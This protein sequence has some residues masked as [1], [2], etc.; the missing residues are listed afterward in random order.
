MHTRLVHSTPRDPC[1]TQR[2]SNHFEDCVPSPPQSAGCDGNT[3]FHVSS[4]NPR[5]RR[6]ISES[7]G[8]EFGAGESDS[9]EQRWP[10]LDEDETDDELVPLVIVGDLD[11]DITDEEAFDHLEDDSQNFNDGNANDE[12]VGDLG[13]PTHFDSG[14][15]TPRE[16]YRGRLEKFGQDK[17]TIERIDMASY[18]ACMEERV[19][20]W[21]AR[22]VP[23]EGSTLDHDSHSC[24]VAGA[25]SD[26]ER[27][28]HEWSESLSVGRDA[29]RRL[30]RILQ[31]HT[32]DRVTCKK[33][34]LRGLRSLRR[35]MD[36]E[37][38]A[39]LGG[40]AS[41]LLVQCD[42]SWAC[43][44]LK[45]PI[46]IPISDPTQAV[47]ML[48]STLY[49]ASFEPESSQ[50]DDRR[51]A[52]CAPMWRYAC[53]LPDDGP[54]RAE[55]QNE[56]DEEVV[57]LPVQLFSDEVVAAPARG[58]GG[59]KL[60]A[61]MM[62][63]V[64]S[65]DRPPEPR[66][67]HVSRQSRAYEPGQTAPLSFMPDPHRWFAKALNRGVADSDPMFTPAFFEA[68]KT[69]R[70][71]WELLLSDA[72]VMTTHRLILE[73]LLAAWRVGMRVT[74]WSGE[75]VIVRP[76]VY[77]F[78]GDLPEKSSALGLKKPN[79]CRCTVCVV[80]DDKSLANITG[81]MQWR[82]GGVDT[83]SL[84]EAET[85]NPARKALD[86]RGFRVPSVC[87]AFNPRTPDGSPMPRCPWQDTRFAA[88]LPAM[89]KFPES[90]LRAL[91]PPEE[92]HD[93]GGGHCVYVWEA[94]KRYLLKQA[95][96][97]QQTA[98]KEEFDRLLRQ[99]PEAWNHDATR[100]V[101]GATV[102]AGM[103]LRKDSLF[104]L[105]L[106]DHSAAQHLVTENLMLVASGCLTKWGKTQEAAQIVRLLA[107]FRRMVQWC[108]LL[109]AHPRPVSTEDMEEHGERV[110]DD[111]LEALRKLLELGKVDP[112]T[113]ARGAARLPNAYPK[114]H[115]TRHFPF[116]LQELGPSQV[117]SASPF[118]KALRYY[119]RDVYHKGGKR[120]IEESLTLWTIGAWR[121]FSR[122][123]RR[124]V[125]RPCEFPPEAPSASS[126]AQLPPPV[127]HG[128]CSLARGRGLPEALARGML[129]DAGGEEKAKGYLLGA[130]QDLAEHPHWEDL[131]LL[132]R[133]FLEGKQWEDL[134]F[135]DEYS[136]LVDSVSDFCG[137]RAVRLRANWYQGP[138]DRGSGGEE[139]TCS[140]LGAY[141][142]PTR[143]ENPARRRR[144]THHG[145]GRRA[146]HHAVE[147]FAPPA[148]LIVEGGDDETLNSI[149]AVRIHGWI[150]LRKQERDDKRAMVI[151]SYFQTMNDDLPGAPPPLHDKL[152]S[153]GMR[154]VYRDSNDPF[155]EFP[156]AV[157]TCRAVIGRAPIFGNPREFGV[158]F[159][160]PRGENWTS[161]IWCSSAAERNHTIRAESP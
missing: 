41:V 138:G 155:R 38:M 147:P 100:R 129:H 3:T 61:A 118:E 124:L 92:M 60:H 79:G 161:Y 81:E 64:A 82:N 63:T 91:F 142:P 136:M 51:R 13:L 111:G 57:A 113:N 72:I 11:D 96:R 36:R 26:L 52:R 37:T 66:P 125:E 58:R 84:Q 67:Q 94:V 148:H 75:K 140:I 95:P 27:E 29:F 145:A 56:A 54:E 17:T 107:A 133:E 141:D 120:E 25:R 62:G 126:G 87:R 89:T 71:E 115:A 86:Q 135:F 149:W 16:P 31:A 106:N 137:R 131:H 44:V 20:R 121:S 55:V 14:T 50:T 151:F 114:F 143:D 108:S 101:F 123:H 9:E 59:R 10:E 99:L 15:S 90:H 69:K 4:E 34:R 153:W 49:H 28:L 40:D 23:I 43:P 12:S 158:D 32:L 116:A 110:V 144:R 5:K 30:T 134:L 7:S 152:A 88:V 117:Y 160:V 109:H 102:A 156:P 19:R 2:P 127:P 93:C 35:A 78:V 112:V 146:A 128:E 132:A 97:G 150:R 77:A 83:T 104:D 85:S 159:P 22:S 119:C 47:A 105:K 45:G 33:P 157:Q 68:S 21:N 8:P 139:L 122:E 24:N 103:A 73:A 39:K 130:L 53:E 42:L 154:C 1:V 6:R 76:L 74:L 98:M 80:P 48:A 70:K 18:A 46:D 65:R